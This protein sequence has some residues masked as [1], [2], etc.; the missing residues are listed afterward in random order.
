MQ[1][2]G[3]RLKVGQ[4]RVHHQRGVD[5]EPPRLSRSLQPLRGWSYEDIDQVFPGDSRAGGSDGA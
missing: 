3:K 4:L 2:L 5:V 1:G